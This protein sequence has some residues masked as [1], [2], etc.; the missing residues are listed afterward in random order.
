[1]KTFAQTLA[2][3]YGVI[4]AC[5]LCYYMITGEIKAKTECIDQ[6]GY[7]IGIFWGCDS[8]NSIRNGSMGGRWWGYVYNSII[9]PSILFK[10]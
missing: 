5:F 2:M 1:M 7:V 6:K 9:W 4:C 3:I 10:K 8:I